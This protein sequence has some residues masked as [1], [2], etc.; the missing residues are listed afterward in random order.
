MNNATAR[1]GSS[2][3]VTFDGETRIEET[4]VVRG[5]TTTVKRVK[6]CPKGII[7]RSEITFGG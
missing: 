7:R 2:F 1:P 3:T 6:F 5:N 4:T